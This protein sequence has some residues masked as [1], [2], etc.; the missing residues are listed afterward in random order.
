MAAEERYIASHNTDTSTTG[1]S[2][3]EACRQLIPR[4]EMEAAW[5]SWIKTE[6]WGGESCNLTQLLGM[7]TMPLTAVFS[8]IPWNI[9][10]LEAPS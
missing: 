8:A 3:G 6:R 1:Q 4:A 9:F 10:S 5:S 2:D 7:P